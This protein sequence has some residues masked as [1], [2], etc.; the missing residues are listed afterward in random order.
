[1]EVR[2]EFQTGRYPYQLT[3]LKRR[4]AA[5][6]RA[7]KE[8]YVGWTSDPES[9]AMGHDSE[10]FSE[11]VVLYRTASVADLLCTRIGVTAHFWDRCINNPGGGGVG[12]P[13]YFI[14]ILR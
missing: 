7:R 4:I 12:N 13:P 9:R 5:L 2:C 8:F 1:M 3:T 6:T 10:R 11:M 14:Y